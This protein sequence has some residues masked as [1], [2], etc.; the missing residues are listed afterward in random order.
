MMD[1]ATLEL[2]YVQ[3]FKDRHGS[4]RHYF[5]RPGWPRVTLPG[6]VG[7]A[8]FMA[9]YQAALAAGKKV[10]GAGAERVKPQSINALIVAYYATAEWKKLRAS[11]QS[12]YKNMLERFRAKHGD[13]SALTIQTRHLEAIFLGMADTPG[14]ARNL[15]KRLRRIFRLAVRL[16]WRADNP[17]TETEA[18]KT[19]P[20]GFAPW[21]EEDIAKFEK[22]WPSGTRQRLALALLLYTGQRRSDVVTLG[23]QHVSNSGRISV[24]QLKT[25]HR[26]TIRIHPALQAEIDAAPLGMTFLLTQYGKPFTAAGFSQWFREAAEEAGLKNRT[27]HGLRKAAGRRLAEAGCTAKEIGAV[28]GHTTLSEIERYTRSADQARLMESALDRLEEAERRTAGGKTL[29][30]PGR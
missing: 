10:G 30:K 7:S 6:E 5:R 14:A 2:K 22:K 16:G 19:A 1:M 25:D 24:T 12:G 23:R 18:P 29:C 17:V 9:A 20:G 15:R 28:L 27:A 21:S 11:T 26:L 13:K 8:E 3:R 4:L